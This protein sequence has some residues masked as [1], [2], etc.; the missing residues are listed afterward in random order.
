[1][2]SHNSFFS[3]HP[4]DPAGFPEQSGYLREVYGHGPA[5]WSTKHT[6]F[7]PDVGKEPGQTRNYMCLEQL[8][9]FFPGS[10]M[11]ILFQAGDECACVI[12]L[13]IGTGYEKGARLVED[14]EAKTLTLTLT[15]DIPKEYVVM[16]DFALKSTSISDDDETLSVKTLVAPEAKW[17]VTIEGWKLHSGALRKGGFLEIVL[18]KNEAQIRDVPLSCDAA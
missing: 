4:A 12:R 13:A 14:L 10:R 3:R 8:L 2:F 6:T 7:T 11:Q 5:A 16:D 15:R 18:H 1:M 9:T 17:T